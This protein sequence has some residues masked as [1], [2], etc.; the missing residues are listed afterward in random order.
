MRF[1]NFLNSDGE[2]VKINPET[3]ESLR[4]TDIEWLKNLKDYDGAVTDIRC[5]SGQIVMVRSTVEDV[6]QKLRYGDS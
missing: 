2:S 5:T 4:A 1:V 3:V 6:E